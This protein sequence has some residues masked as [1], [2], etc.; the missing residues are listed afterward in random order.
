L[1]FLIFRANFLALSHPLGNTPFFMSSH[2]SLRRFV[3]V[4]IFG[5][6]SVFPATAQESA[7]ELAFNEAERFY[8]AGNRQTDQYEKGRYMNHV[9]G[10]YIKYL[11]N[12]S[13]S[14]NVPA[15]RFHLGYARQTLGRIEEAK[16]TYQTLIVHHKKGPYVGSAA[17]QLA[18]LA[19]LEEDRD[20]A[21]RYFGLAAANLAHENLRL[22]AL[23]KQ[24]KCLTE[25]K[26]TEDLAVIMRAIIDSPKHP[27]HDWAT[28]MLGYQYYEADDFE[29][30]IR[31][32]APLLAEETPSE[33]RSQALFYTG[34]AAAELGRD[35][36]AETHLRSILEMPMDHPSLTR[37]QRQH[38]SVNKAKAQ[39]SLMGLYS[40]KK[41]WQTVIDLY[42][43]GDFGATAKT[44]ARRCMRAGNAYFR[45]Q[46]YLNARAAFR[47]VDRSLPETSIAFQAS[48]KCLQCDYLLRRS[49]LPERIESFFELYS[50][51]FPGHHLLHTARFYQ[52]E[53]LYQ[54]NAPEKA[55]LAFNRVTKEK[56]APAYRPELLFKHGWC[57]SES[58]Q[59][60][61]ATRSF[62]HFL[63][64]FPNDARKAIAHN[65]RGEAHFALGDF[66][67][68][69]RD[70]EAVLALDA[71]P[72]QTP[73]ALQGSGRV[74]RGDKKYKAMIARYRRILS[75][76]PSLPRDTIA[77]ANY[78]IGW[79]FYEQQEYDE[80]PA[81]LRKARNLVP[82]FY[83][84]PVGDL[85]ILTAFNQRDKAA[86]HLALQEVFAM[87][88]AK[89]IPPH[90]LSWLGVQMYHDGQAE[91]AI[92]YLG[93]ATNPSKPEQ[94]DTAV[95]RI[96]AKAQNRTANFEDAQRTGQLLL[97]L[98]QE[99]RWQ[100]DA[101]LDLAE[102]QLGLNNLDDSLESATNGLALDA[103]GS[104]VAGLHLIRGEIALY[105]NQWAEAL[106]SFQTTITMVPDDPILQPRALFGASLAA[107]KSGN[108]NLA[109][110]LK[111]QLENTFPDFKSTIKLTEANKEQ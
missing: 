15:A 9:I 57:L 98:K 60:D 61:G 33:H 4:L 75:E 1:I 40:K 5:W 76:F 58:G 101:Y 88:P 89:S 17:R 49:D 67:A 16:T 91:A 45:L 21:A 79:G 59:F 12:Y 6:L 51:K 70:F 68:A 28:F 102:A 74:L 14:K 104:H 110:D 103:P 65:K 107:E 108:L 56:L 82:E 46:N 42:E 11:N 105:Q 66:N 86:L 20:A 2:P 64:D 29:T 72:E 22:I 93:R 39:T 53:S 100:A 62:G 32:L 19:Y 10:L 77:N 25:L 24:I 85:L 69:L 90:M 96:L 78:W 63:A 52:G 47:D 94:T 44:E 38:L 54:N 48:F 81:Y 8:A 99:P 35:D 71:G 31:T 84:Q 80:A 18:Y 36:V 3:I 87:A 23:K 109:R 7:E 27:Y 106:T 111:N 37:E 55:A 43:M 41:D 92:D 97:K 73:F 83:T 95:W 13:R 34:L 26:R 50:A 30:T